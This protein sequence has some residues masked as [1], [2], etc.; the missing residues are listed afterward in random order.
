MSDGDDRGTALLQH[1]GGVVREMLDSHPPHLEISPNTLDGRTGSRPSRHLVDGPIDRRHKRKP[2]TRPTVLVPPAGASK[3]VARFAREINGEP[4]PASSST[5]RWR[6]C[7]HGSVGDSPA[8]TMR[9][10][11]SISSA[12]ATRTAASSS[13]CSSRLTNSSAARFA[14]S[15]SVSASASRQR[16]S[17][18]IAIAT[19]STARR[20]CTWPGW[21]LTARA[22]GAPSQATG[23]P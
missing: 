13:A 12:H 7:S 11:R 21:G 2:E 4:H 10:R 8:I 14:R 15:S 5:S 23:R 1:V 19:K 6:T 22:H 16:S 20:P 18:F 9:A 17:A 3:L